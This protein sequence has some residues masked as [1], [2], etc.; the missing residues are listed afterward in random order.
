MLPGDHD[1][2]TEDGFSFGDA[3][4]TPL[5]DVRDAFARRCWRDLAEVHAVHDKG[6]NWRM[7]MPGRV[8]TPVEIAEMLAT[9]TARQ[10]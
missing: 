2:R 4:P 3:R 10:S 1:G 6:A 8:L 7:K 5:P 9:A